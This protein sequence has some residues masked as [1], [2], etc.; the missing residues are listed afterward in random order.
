MNK[1]MRVARMIRLPLRG[2]KD[3]LSPANYL[4]SESVRRSLALM[5][6]YES[7]VVEAN[8]G[9]LHYA[10][11]CTL[12]GGEAEIFIDRVYDFM[13]TRPD[14]VVVDCGAN[15]G[16]AS[17]WFAKKFPTSLI[18]AYEADPSLFKLLQK[19]ISSHGL[20]KRVFPFNFA[21][22]RDA[23][24]VEFDQE[25]GFSGQI[26]RYKHQHVK[27]TVRVPSITLA[28]LLEP[29]PHVDL[30][31]ID[32]EGAEC[33]IFDIGLD[34]TK[35]DRVFLEYHSHERDPQVL[36][37]IL[38]ILS[39]NGFRY[40]IREAYPSKH[41]FLKVDSLVGMDLQLN[42]YAYRLS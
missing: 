14:P 5:P 4:L 37:Q 12:I 33:Q 7:G 25:G 17:L 2:T 22:W 9:L 38:S 8:G 40:H 19:N 15:I 34:L 11:A 18:Y 32:I 36:G 31:K 42:I 39:L 30:L 6:R 1:A 10:D 20:Q 13:Q 24:G 26:S 35:P 27:N 21:I 29:L 23:S 16:L 41:P 28:Q 3:S